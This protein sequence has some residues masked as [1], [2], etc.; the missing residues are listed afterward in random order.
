M[1]EK[2][3]K[4]NNI[5]LNK[6][7]FHKSK[8]PIDLMSVNVD[9]IVVFDKFRHS[10]EHF[11]YFVGYQGGEIVK[12]LCIILPQMS[13]YIKYV[14][15]GGKNMSFLLKIIKCGKNTNKFAM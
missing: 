4:F 13:E 7:E 6:K 1:S 11:I 3:L 15:N 10:D 9:Q 12:P 14:E 2:T 5:R 8:Q